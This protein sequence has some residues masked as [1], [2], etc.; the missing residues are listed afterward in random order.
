MWEKHSGE[1]KKFAFTSDKFIFEEYYYLEILIVYI[2]LFEENL[3]IYH[4]QI[5]VKKYIMLILKIKNFS[6]N[7]IKSMPFYKN[8]KKKKL[9]FEGQP[10]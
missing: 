8:G 10:H 7:F 1:Y 2:I 4:I 3:F 9:C 6:F 5:W